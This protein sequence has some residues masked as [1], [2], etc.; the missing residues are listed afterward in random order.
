MTPNCVLK[1]QGERA[2]ERESREE[3]PKRD[4]GRCGGPG[5]VRGRE[6]V[7]VGGR[8][9]GAESSGLPSASS[10]GAGGWRGGTCPQTG[11]AGMKA[12][13]QRAS[14]LCRMGPS[15]AVVEPQAEVT[16]PQPPSTV[17]YVDRGRAVRQALP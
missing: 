12:Q 9:G 1:D 2:K 11:L 5:V 4:T 13:A 7:Q 16:S 15:G 14:G 8:G 10:W 6:A 17:S 3:L